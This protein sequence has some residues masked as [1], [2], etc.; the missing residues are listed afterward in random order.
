[1]AIRRPSPDLRWA[2]GL[3]AL[4]LGFAFVLPFLLGAR[5]SDLDAFFWP[6]AE[7]AAHG[8]PLLVYTVE[9]GPYPD[10]NGPLSLVP[11]TLVAV[12]ANAVGWAG[13][14]QLHDGLALAVFAGFSLLMAREATRLADRGAAA[15]RGRAV[16]TAIFLSVPLWLALGSFGH[17]EVPLE[18]WLTLS[19]LR[20]TLDRRLVPA[21]AV[22]GLVI[23]TRSAAA[24]MVLGLALLAG[25]EDATARPGQRAARSLIVIAGSATTVMVGLLPFLVA[26]RSGVVSSLLTFRSALPISGG[27]AW[28]LLARGLPWEGI[29]QRDDAFIFTGAAF[30]MVS[31]VLWRTRGQRM[32]VCRSTALLTIAACCVPL[33]SKTTW[34]YYLT[35][36]Y[37]LAVVWTL[38]RPGPL[39]L[40]RWGVPGLLS[41][42]SALLAV[43]GLSTPPT[44]LQAVVG[45]ASSITVA[46][47][48]GLVMRGLIRVTGPRRA[49]DA[50]ALVPAGVRAPA[51]LT[52]G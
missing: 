38:S 11:L 1:M 9:A 7:M 33:L 41:A 6:A 36:P 42:L 37:V 13:D 25:A 23:L 19:A 46:V 39:T 48:I 44:S 17:V 28:L 31:A 52:P 12:V 27:S 40:R 47:T 16:Y 10:A 29:V 32:D 22:M 14:Q 18:M 51:D 3:G 45:L 15:Q 4:Y 21:A 30:L 20:L 49:A 8:H 50:A 26:D 2:L 35:E 5:D 34:A 43:T 24:V